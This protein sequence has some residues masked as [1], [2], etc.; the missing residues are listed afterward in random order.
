MIET[1]YLGPAEGEAAGGGFRKHRT[2]WDDVISTGMG[3][4]LTGGP[5]RDGRWSMTQSGAKAV[6][7]RGL[8]GTIRVSLSGACLWEFW[9]ECPLTVGGG[10]ARPRE[11]SQG[12]CS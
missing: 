2:R 3:T 12:E 8:R 5:S 11:R 10:E 7:K 4:R 1:A 6:P 9:G